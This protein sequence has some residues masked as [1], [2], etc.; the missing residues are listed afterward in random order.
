MGQT[1]F[2]PDELPIL[3]AAK[4]FCLK[5]KKGN[6]Y[7]LIIKFKKYLFGGRWPTR[8]LPVSWRPSPTLSVCTALLKK[9]VSAVTASDCK[10]TNVENA[11]V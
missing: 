10:I 11:A 9:A 6:I 8:N 5:N 4:L 1:N 2:G 7:F 3:T